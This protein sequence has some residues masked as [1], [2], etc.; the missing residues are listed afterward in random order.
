MHEL[1]HLISFDFTHYF[2]RFKMQSLE[3]VI[4]PDV[5]FEETNAFLETTLLMKDAR[6]KSSSITSPVFYIAIQS[7]LKNAY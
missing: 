5:S 6:D 1:G 7:F 4:T 3:D 2:V